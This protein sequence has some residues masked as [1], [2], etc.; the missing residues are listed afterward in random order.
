MFRRKKIVPWFLLPALLCIMLFICS[1]ASASAALV[2]PARQKNVGAKAYY[3]DTSLQAVVLQEGIVSIGSQAFANSS[4]TDITLPS[5]LTSIADDAFDGAPLTT[6][7]AEKGSMAYR[8]MR[9]KGLISEYR[10]LLIGQNRFVWFSDESAPLAGYVLD[11]QDESRNIGDVLNLNAALNNVIGPRGPYS[12]AEG[13]FQVTQK[14]NQSYSDLRSAIQS[15]FADTQ[16]QDISVFFIATHG[17]ETADGELRTAFT[18][19]IADRNQVLQ[20]WSYRHLPFSTLASWLKTYVKGRVFVILESCGSGSAIY[21]E[22]VEENRRRL[23]SAGFTGQKNSIQ[24]ENTEKKRAELFVEKAVEA[25]SKADPGISVSVQDAPVPAPKKST[26]DLRLP[27]FYVLAASRHQEKSYGWENNEHIPE[28]SYNYFTKWLTEGIGRQDN[29]PADTNKNNF[30][31][32][33]EMFNH[34]KKHDHITYQGITYEQHVQR[35]PAGSGDNLLK[36]RE[37]FSYSVTGIRGNPHLFR[38]GKS[39]EYTVQRS[40]RDNETFSR[41]ESVFVD[42]LA[43]EPDC[44]DIQPGSLVLTLKSSYLN[45]LPEGSYKVLIRFSDGETETGLTVSRQV[46]ATG[47]NSRPLLWLFMLLTGLAGL[48]FLWLRK[49]EKQ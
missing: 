37:S 22:G 10:A 46:P 20:Y 4:L 24:E 41:F 17:Q 47:D 13:A 11:E 21:A 3:G 38:R 42:K 7:H 44:Y 1:A 9:E 8:W 30:L 28:K 32:L 19:N 35:Y 43:L 40:V 33:E 6:V 15:T 29:S 34:V 2:I 14:T 12:S 26:G 48:G 23:D 36:L 31:T 18:G 49:A 16:E 25:F 45:T 27:K 5:T 39:T